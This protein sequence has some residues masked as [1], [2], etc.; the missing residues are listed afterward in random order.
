LVCVPALQL[1]PPPPAPHP[2]IVSANKA[3][4]IRQ[5][6]KAVR[7]AR[8]YQR[9]MPM[10]WSIHKYP[11][12]AGRPR[13]ARQAIVQAAVKEHRRSFGWRLLVVFS[14]V[15]GGAL[16]PTLRPQPRHA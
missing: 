8:W 16:A 13:A 15:A 3:S 14:A 2:P 9:R 7:T 1:L 11:D 4:P 10:Y 12:L 6:I 5:A